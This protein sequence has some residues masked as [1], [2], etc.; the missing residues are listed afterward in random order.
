VNG[1]VDPWQEFHNAVANLGRE[2]AKA[3]RLHEIVDW[4]NRRLTK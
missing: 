2:I 3:L 4:L 1:P